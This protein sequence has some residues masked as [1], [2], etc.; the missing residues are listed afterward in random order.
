MHLELYLGFVLATTI[1]ILIPGPNVSLIVGRA[2]R[3]DRMGPLDR[4]RLFAVPRLLPVECAAA[5]VA[6]LRTSISYQ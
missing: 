6:M 2:G 4:C 5:V 3:M 1:L